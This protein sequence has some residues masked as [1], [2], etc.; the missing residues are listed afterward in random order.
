MFD[1]ITGT[2][3]EILHGASSMHVMLMGYTVVLAEFSRTR[4]SCCTQPR[5]SIH[6]AGYRT[7]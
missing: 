2:Q 4:L 6:Q 7:F 1:E 3:I 5:K